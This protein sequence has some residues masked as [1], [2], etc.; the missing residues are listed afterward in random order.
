[1]WPR[2]QV[3]V[4]DGG[5]TNLMPQFLAP[6]ATYL[7]EDGGGSGTYTLSVTS[8]WNSYEFSLRVISNNEVEIGNVPNYDG[9]VILKRS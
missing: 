7:L 3:I 5:E 2:G 9:R 4:F 6:P 1:M 8:G